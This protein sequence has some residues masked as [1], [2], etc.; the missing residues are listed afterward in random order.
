MVTEIFQL[1]RLSAAFEVRRV[2]F[3]SVSCR[4]AMRNVLLF[5]TS[6]SF[7][8]KAGCAS[9]DAATPTATPLAAPDLGDVNPATAV[10]TASL[11]MAAPE[12]QESNIPCGEPVILFQD[13]ETR[14][15]YIPPE[16]FEEIGEGEYPENSRQCDPNPGVNSPTYGIQIEM[17]TPDGR[18]VSFMLKFKDSFCKH[19][20]IFKVDMAKTFNKA[21]EDDIAAAEDF[22]DRGFNC[23][24]AA[25]AIFAEAAE[26]DT[27]YAPI[28]QILSGES[29]V[30]NWLKEMGLFDF[31]SQSGLWTEVDAQKAQPGDLVFYFQ[32]QEIENPGIT[33][34]TRLRDRDGMEIVRITDKYVYVR[35]PS[36]S[37]VVNSNGEHTSKPGIG[38]TVSMESEVLQEAYCDAAGFDCMRVFRPK[39]EFFDMDRLLELAD[40]TPQELFDHFSAIKERP[41][42]EERHNI[43][44]PESLLPGVE[45]VISAVSGMLGRYSG[46]TV[47]TP[48]ASEVS[49]LLD[50]VGAYL[51]LLQNFAAVGMC[52]DYYNAHVALSVRQTGVTRKRFNQAKEPLDTAGIDSD[53]ALSLGS[54]ISRLQSHGYLLWEAAI[55]LA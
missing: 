48:S 20:P 2:A 15:T 27:P 12:Q 55:A 40:M 10:P 45:M 50:N 21:T 29:I 52:M 18:E 43:V 4:G 5:S 31:V 19:P 46:P 41:T 37:V 6:L 32:T 1:N 30:I 8:L 3:P 9:T 51:S 38:G 22:N 35:L 28:F 36:H 14:V 7:L 33:E 44:P 34:D 17:L 25:L 16:H 13:G 26:P 47:E 24:A 39:G 54:R 42:I 23:H 53:E 49:A 11:P